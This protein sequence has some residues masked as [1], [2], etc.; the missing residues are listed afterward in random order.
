M[1]YTKPFY[2]HTVHQVRIVRH[3]M[4]FSLLHEDERDRF[5]AAAIDQLL[6]RGVIEDNAGDGIL[7]FTQPFYM[8]L[9]S[10][11]GGSVDFRGGS[12]PTSQ[13]FEE[14]SVDLPDPGNSPPMPF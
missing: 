7:D 14:H 10:F 1:T 11:R 12:F 4:E 5:D 3:L 8:F 2:L 13:F 6:E 9:L